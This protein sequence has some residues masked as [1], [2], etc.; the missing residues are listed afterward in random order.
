MTS[1]TILLTLQALTILLTL[2]A[3]AGNFLTIYFAHKAEEAGEWEEDT[4]V[5]EGER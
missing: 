3:L 1:L 5:L 4:D 2:L